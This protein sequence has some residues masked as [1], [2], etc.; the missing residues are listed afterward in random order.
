MFELSGILPNTIII[1]ITIVIN[2]VNRWYHFLQLHIFKTKIS[3]W[4]PLSLFHLSGIIETMDDK[5]DPCDNFYQYA[6][7]GWLKRTPIPDSRTRYSRFEKLSE[8]NNIVLKQILNDLIRK[9]RNASVSFSF[10]LLSVFL[11][12]LQFFRMSKSVL[13]GCFF[14][15]IILN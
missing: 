1:I 13:S 15:S 12:I 6:C 3:Q 10:L 9:K 5:V 14:P 8:K 11:F 2:F 4:F 7:G